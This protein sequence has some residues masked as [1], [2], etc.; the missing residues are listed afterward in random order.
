MQITMALLAEAANRSDNDRLNLLGVFHTLY[1]A[2]TPCQ[3]PMMALVVT[4]E[5]TAMERGMHMRVGIRLV[6][7]D[8]K[9]I[10][11]PL[12]DAPVDIPND[13]STLTPKVNLIANIGGVVFE[14]FGSYQFD[15]LIE[16]EVRGQI[17][18]TIAPL[19]RAPN[20]M[21]PPQ[22]PPSM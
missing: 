10:T 3:H 13:P 6:N 15:I 7:A 5:G 21:G 4:F 14:S 8:G 16:G 11:T 17:P 12:L 19:S 2:T 1:A 9:P 22:L 20:Q 18:L